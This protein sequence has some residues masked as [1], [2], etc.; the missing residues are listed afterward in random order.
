MRQGRER[1]DAAKAAAERV[2]QLENS[3]AHGAMPIVF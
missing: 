2:L 1:V 3:I